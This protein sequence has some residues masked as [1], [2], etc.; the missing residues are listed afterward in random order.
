MATTRHEKTASAKCWL[1]RRRG[2][3]GMGSDLARAVPLAILL[4]ALAAL[5]ATAT[6][7]ETAAEQGRAA[8]PNG[9]VSASGDE[10]TAQGA[11]GAAE[12][13]PGAQSRAVGTSGRAVNIAGNTADNTAEKAAESTALWARL[14][15][16][17]QAQGRFE[18]ALYSERGELLER[19]SGR[20]ALLKP[21]FLRW[22]I[23]RPDR[24]RL[25]VAAGQIWHYDIDLATATRRA[26]RRGESFSALDLLTADTASLRQRFQ[27][28]VLGDNS[29][30]NSGDQRYRLLP[31]FPG[32][33]FAVL[34]LTWRDGRLRAMSIRD[35]SAQHIQLALTPDPAA[36]PLQAQDFAFEPPPGVEVFAEP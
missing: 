4:G 1:H 5:S 13:A 30:E 20:Y 23:E 36:A 18:Q 35:R 28:E 7:T 11:R 6:A 21:G 19:S 10:G 33:E 25:V 26:L 27:V 16:L 14:A 29:G 2:T 34:E 31:L 22:E 9:A 17:D 8:A 24:Q 3:D 15:G 32:A 12:I